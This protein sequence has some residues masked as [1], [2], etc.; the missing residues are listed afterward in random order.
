MVTLRTPAGAENEESIICIMNGL[1]VQRL[2]EENEWKG[3]G[4]RSFIA[5]RKGGNFFR[6]MIGLRPFMQKLI[7]FYNSAHASPTLDLAGEL[8]QT[9]WVS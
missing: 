3:M 6:G 1:G 2:N 5:F 4:G 7:S 9:G 8:V